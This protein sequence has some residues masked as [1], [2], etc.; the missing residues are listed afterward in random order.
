M[1]CK[2]FALA[3]GTSATDATG[4]RVRLPGQRRAIAL[5]EELKAD[6]L[7]LDDTEARKEAARRKLLSI[8]TLGILREAAARNLVSLPSA[9][10]RIQQ[11]TFYADPALIQFL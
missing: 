11:T 3:S 4:P 8:G 6:R 7:L 10:A 5:A 9:L 1:A 2:W